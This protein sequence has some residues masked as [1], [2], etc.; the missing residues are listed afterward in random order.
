MYRVTY[1]NGVVQYLELIT[2]DEFS[3]MKKAD[4]DKKLMTPRLKHVQSKIKAGTMFTDNS[5]IYKA[6]LN[7]GDIILPH[8]MFK[9]NVELVH[10][11]NTNTE[12]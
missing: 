4:L 7:G 2:Q 10:D 3:E 1:D 11:I 8:G 9:C 6:Y 12:N 5:P